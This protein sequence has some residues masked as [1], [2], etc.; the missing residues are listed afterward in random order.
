M[1]LSLVPRMVIEPDQ[2][3]S[4]NQDKQHRQSCLIQARL[5]FYGEAQLIGTYLTYYRT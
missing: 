2:K 1:F 3:L 4:R 5:V